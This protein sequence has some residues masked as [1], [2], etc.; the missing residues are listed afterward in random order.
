MVD[1][2]TRFPHKLG[3]DCAGSVVEVGSEVT[4]FKVGDEVY[5]RLHESTRGKFFFN[6]AFCYSITSIRCALY[7]NCQVISP[8]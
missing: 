5:S 3:Y 7:V 6:Y 4:R 2:A 8:I 1:A